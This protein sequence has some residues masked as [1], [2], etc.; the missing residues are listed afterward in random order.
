M[1]DGHVV[2]DFGIVPIAP[3]PSDARDA[4]LEGVNVMDDGVLGESHVGRR[5]RGRDEERFELATMEEFRG[6]SKAVAVDLSFH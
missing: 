5:A 4:V 1:V 2:E 6:R 3:R